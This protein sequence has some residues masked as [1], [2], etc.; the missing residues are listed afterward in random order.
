MGAGFLPKG[1]F[2]IVHYVEVDDDTLRKI[3]E[4]LKI[5]AAELSRL[6]SG[7]IHVLS[8]SGSPKKG[9]RKK[10]ARPRKRPG[11]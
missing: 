7:S 5:P 4:L 8:K 6:H 1:T 3:G 9:A 10:A 11:P 2:K